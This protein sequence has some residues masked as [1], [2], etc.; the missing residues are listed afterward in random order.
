MG[1]I[2][3][4]NIASREFRWVLGKDGG[5]RLRLSSSALCIPVGAGGSSIP[6]A[7][8]ARH[9]KHRESPNVDKRY[10]GV[11]RIVQVPDEKLGGLEDQSARGQSLCVAN[12]RFLT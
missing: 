12:D 6:M 3:L 8:I 4:P 2:E 1:D 9:S 5:C 7:C 11:V 10:R